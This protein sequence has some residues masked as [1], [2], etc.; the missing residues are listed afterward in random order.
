MSRQAWAVVPLPGNLPGVS[1]S[2][3]EEETAVW[4]TLAVME[5]PGPIEAKKKKPQLPTIRN[6]RLTVSLDAR[7]AEYLAKNNLSYNMLVRLALEEFISVERTWKLEPVGR[8]ESVRAT[9]YSLHPHARK[10]EEED[11]LDN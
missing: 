4:Y 1:P 10:R 7:V 8:A 2:P 3:P 9:V 6:T 5:K 11:P